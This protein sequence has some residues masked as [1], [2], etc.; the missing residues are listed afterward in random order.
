MS[1]A[2]TAT[3]MSAF[4]APDSAW[5]QSAPTPKP[6]SQQPSLNPQNFIP[7]PPSIAAK[8]WVLMDARTGNI[9][10]QH[11]E[12]EHLPPASLTK[13]M[14]AYTTEYE[15]A[16]GRLH[17]DDTATVSTNAW[18]T[19]G[20][21]M[22]L[23]PNTQVPISELLRGLIVV[24]GNDAAVTLAEHIAGSEGA[25]AQ[26]MNEHAQMMGLKD[27]H[28]MNPTGLPTPDHY[29]SAH[30]LAVLAR[31]IIYDFPQYYSTYKEKYFTYNNIKQPNRVL[32]LW[33]DPRV[34][35]LK[36]GFTDAAGYCMLTSGVQGNTR[37]IAVVLGTASEAA[38]AQQSETLLNY[39]FRYYHT[40]QL[41]PANHV[42]S[43]PRVWG[44]ADTHVKVGF[45]KPLLVTLPVAQ[46]NLTQQVQLPNSINAPIKKGQQLGTLTVLRNGKEITSQP[47]I[48]LSDDPE[49]GLFRRLSDSIVRT[50]SGWF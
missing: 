37:L 8:A 39:G 44:G 33:R 5:A 3:S 22:F 15:L 24:S 34:D 6:D 7:D 25:F 41:F 18:H 38:R 30:D 42:V 21:R 35:G 1:A 26:L 46:G 47:I 11:D 9:I 28:Y 14:T 32:L 20:S 49:G 19:G 13:L 27:T 40:Q 48:A 2:L 16:A 31:H 43:T 23:K 4:V 29:T 12:N 36:T 45:D 50:V 17:P 10:Y